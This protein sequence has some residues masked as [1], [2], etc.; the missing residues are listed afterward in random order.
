MV[1]SGGM[2]EVLAAMGEAGGC[3]TEGSAMAPAAVAVR[4]RLP[5]GT[6]ARTATGDASVRSLE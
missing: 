1:V 6:A 2:K 3:H 4:P 5:A